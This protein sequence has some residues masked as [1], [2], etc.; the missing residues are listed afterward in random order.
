LILPESF[1]LLFDLE[2]F[3]RYGLDW[4]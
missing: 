1:T 2:W 4:M 3:Y